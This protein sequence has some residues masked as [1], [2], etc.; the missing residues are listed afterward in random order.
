MATR[1]ILCFGD[2]NTWGFIPVA[3]PPSSR[4]PAEQRWPQVMR[5]ILGG[6]VEVIEEGLNGR[7]TDTPDPANPLLGGA[8]L[9]GSA[10]LPACLASHLPLH[11]V[12]I[13][14]GSNDTK[15]H[16]G[17]T[18]ARIAQ[19]AKRL[20]DIVRTLDGGVGTSYPNPR[21]LLVCPPPLGTLSPAFT[22]MFAGGVEKTRLMPPLYQAAAQA[23]GA[24][25]L[26]AG[27]VITTDGVDG[28]HL[29]AEMQR[30]LGQAVA[31]ALA[32]ALAG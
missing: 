17:R 10:Y 4:Y 21:L 18:A 12:V 30:R 25:F 1:R 9:D 11:D 24:A 32:G 29:S 20:L 15:P 13:M 28:V 23:A 27:T 31:G 3:T 19:G 8:G 22:E 14:L 26:D 7:T 2:S 6:D 16:L 5:A